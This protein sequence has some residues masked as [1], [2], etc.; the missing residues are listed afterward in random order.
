MRLRLTLIT[1]ALIA[2]GCASSKKASHPIAGDWDYRVITD[3]RTYAGVL[4]LQ[5]VDKVLQGTMTTAGVEGAGPLANLKYEAP[6]LRFDV[7]SP[8]HGLLNVSLNFDGDSFAGEM[9]VP[10]YGVT[11]PMTGTRKSDV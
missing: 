6:G 1:L 9:Y 2:F 4:S 8:E 5:V 3:E 11:I 10:R 7:T